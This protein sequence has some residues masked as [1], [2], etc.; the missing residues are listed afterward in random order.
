MYQQ[1]PHQHPEAN[2]RMLGY[3]L[4]I[5][6]EAARS[7]GYVGD[8]DRNLIINFNHDRFIFDSHWD[9]SIVK[10]LY[11]DNDMNIDSY[12]AFIFDGKAEY[13]RDEISNME[14]LHNMMRLSTK[15]QHLNWIK[16]TSSYN[17]D[18]LWLSF[19]VKE[20]NK[21]GYCVR[22]ESGNSIYNIVEFIDD[23]AYVITIIAADFISRQLSVPLVNTLRTCLI[24]VPHNY[25]YRGVTK[26]HIPF[27]KYP[28]Y[29]TFRSVMRG[30]VGDKFSGI[31]KNDKDF[32]EAF[33][34]L[35]NPNIIVNF[36]VLE[37]GFC[38]NILPSIQGSKNSNEGD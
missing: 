2:E 17:Q 18:R 1:Q 33:S 28:E 38:N 34:K 3:T 7:V 31:L 8:N 14:R 23:D 10:G 12:I 30:D 20:F 13:T 9:E 11:A 29:D 16:M 35:K 4:L 22:T 15:H 6:E 26:F 32:S 21:S 36:Q 19:P 5:G 24:D 37:K 27:T 25:K